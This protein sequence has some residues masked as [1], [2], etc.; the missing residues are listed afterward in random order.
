MEAFSDGV[1]AVIITIMV[2]EIHVPS[3]KDAPTGMAALREIAPLLLVYLLSFIQTGI[4]WVN[5]HYLIL[6]LKHVTHGILWTNLAVLFAMSLMPAATYWVAVRG[7]SP[8]SIG[9]YGLACVAPSLPWMVLSTLICKSSGKHPAA[10]FGKQGASVLLYAGS[11]AVARVS[12]Y[13]SLALVGA[14]A[15]MWLL[16]PKQIVELMKRDGNTAE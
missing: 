11:I 10:G 15:V 1:I 6:G 7:L 4:Y 2:L 8:F 14:V 5:H 13:L 3:M 16:P 9:L 12:P